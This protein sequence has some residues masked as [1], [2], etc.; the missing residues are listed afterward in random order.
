MRLPLRLRLT[1]AFACGM[2][3]VLSTLGAFLYLRLASELLGSIDMGLRSRAEIVVSGLG[4]GEGGLI[5]ES[6]GLIDPDEAFAQVLG[7]EGS[8]SIVDSSPAVAGAPMLPTAEL[9]TIDRPTFLDRRV[10]GVEDP[11]R[12]FVVPIDDG[13]GRRF[14]VVG[15]VLS[16]RHE[17]LSRLLVL[18]A[19]GG[20][21]ALALVSTAG[22]VLAGAALRPVER[23][24]QEAAAISASEPER[25]LPV[26]PTGDELARLATTLNGMLERLQTSLGAE[27][28]F[29]DD[30]SHELRT[31]LGVLKGELDL[32]LSRPR[33]AGELETTL[34]RASEETDRLARLAEDLLVLSRS[35]GGRLPVH[36]EEIRLGELLEEA[37][38]DHRDGSRA[39]G[40]ELI[41]TVP[42]DDRARV[43]PARLRQAVENLVDNAIRHVRPGGTIE[44]EAQI[45]DGVACVS[46]RDSGPGFPP[47]ILPRAFEPFARGDGAGAGLG[48][49]I[50]RAVAEAHGGTASAENLPE[51][52]SRVEIVLGP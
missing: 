20:P 18:F 9:R 27:R 17:A 45:D 15:A 47:E 50:V 24:R 13:A 2:T 29:V 36:P 52:G 23:M 40:I 51:G 30:A 10:A 39:A 4:D 7:L 35:E 12:L 25:R 16:D 38:R 11:A 3:L 6:G 34:R 22:W 46:V 31:P 28:R 26:P 32:A 48:L 5:D 8:A 41:I 43:D 44:V 14:V 19:I 1:L 49:A 33:T 37:C 21:V 42:A